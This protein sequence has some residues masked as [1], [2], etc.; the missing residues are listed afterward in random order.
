MS[1]TSVTHHR[2]SI[3]V[4]RAQSVRSCI[5][6]EY[7]TPLRLIGGCPDPHEFSKSQIHYTPVRTNFFPGGRKKVQACG[8]QGSLGSPSTSVPI[9]IAAIGPRADA[10][11]PA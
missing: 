1:V 10:Q 2:S 5:A 4:S 8:P 9:A 6:T 7:P 3:S 11:L